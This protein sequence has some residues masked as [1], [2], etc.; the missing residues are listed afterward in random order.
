MQIMAK[1]YED[2][3]EIWIESSRT[4]CDKTELPSRGL[5]IQYPHY[6]A[7]EY[8]RKSSSL[9]QFIVYQVLKYQDIHQCGWGNDRNMKASMFSWVVVIHNLI[10][11]YSWAPLEES[12]CFFSSTVSPFCFV[13]LSIFSP[14]TCQPPVYEMSNVDDLLEHLQCHV[15]LMWSQLLTP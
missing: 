9:S 1:V 10:I 5:K 15:F 7:I 6:N 3:L 4:A 8:G 2:K 13:F 14:L 11:F 12:I